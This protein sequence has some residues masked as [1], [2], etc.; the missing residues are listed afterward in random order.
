M[1]RLS[2][3]G[4]FIELNPLL[5]NSET[6]GLDQQITDSRWVILNQIYDRFFEKNRSAEFGSEKPN[7]VLKARFEEVFHSGPFRVLEQSPRS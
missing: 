1:P 2:P 6:S 5:T 3:S 4:Y 7:L